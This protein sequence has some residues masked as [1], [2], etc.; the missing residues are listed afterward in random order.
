MKRVLPHILFLLCG[1]TLGCTTYCAL[2]LLI[3]VGMALD[4]YP[5]FTL[6]LLAAFL[7]MGTVSLALAYLALRLWYRHEPKG[8]TVI[9]YAVE[10]AALLL[11]GMWVCERILAWLQQNF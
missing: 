8:W 1:L 2:D 7:L 6:F 5:R 11:P 3:I 9:L 10:A 4:L